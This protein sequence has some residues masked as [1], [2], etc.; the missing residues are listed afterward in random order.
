MEQII[1]PVCG[2]TAEPGK[3]KSPDSKRGGAFTELT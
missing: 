3:E 2:S 1:G